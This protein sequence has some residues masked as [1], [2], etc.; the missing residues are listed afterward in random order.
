[1]EKLINSEKKIT[2]AIIIIFI[3]SLTISLWMLIND[4]LKLTTNPTFKLINGLDIIWLNRI[5]EWISQLNN[6]FYIFII[7]SLI[8]YAIILLITQL[9]N[10]YLLEKIKIKK[11]VS[12]KNLIVIT[13][14]DIFLIIYTYQIIGYTW[15]TSLMISSEKIITYTQVVVMLLLISKVLI[16]L[17]I[18]F[19]HYQIQKNQ[20]NLKKQINSLYL[21]LYRATLILLFI[22]FIINIIRVVAINLFVNYLISSISIEFIFSNIFL[23]FNFN[24]NVSQ[25]LPVVVIDAIEFI[26]SFRNIEINGLDINQIKIN[27][28]LNATVIK[29]IDNWLQMIINNISDSIIFRFFNYYLIGFIIS[30]ILLIVNRY[31]AI[32]QK[33]NIYYD[34]FNYLMLL[35]LAIIFS[36]GLQSSLIGA[37]LLILIYLTL[38]FGLVVNIMISKKIK[39]PRN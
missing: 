9:M 6:W 22:Y 3:I 25:V 33:M 2:L 10:Y 17:T 38:L 23:D 27:G 35:I 16:K 4:L 11:N 28:L 24:Q 39:I 20:V 15:L 34:Y 7:V 36:T 31:Q 19:Q 21:I 14:L 32:N 18:I 26:F 37:L 30:A 13:I 8:S 1:M 29:P 5:F 12:I